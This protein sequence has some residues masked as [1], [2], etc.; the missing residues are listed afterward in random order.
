M[1]V[2]PEVGVRANF[3]F[4]I[5]SIASLL[6]ANLLYERG[7]RLMWDTSCSMILLYSLLALCTAISLGEL[8]RNIMQLDP[9]PSSRFDW[10]LRSWVTFPGCECLPI[11]CQ[12]QAGYVD[13][14]QY[15]MYW[16]R[17]CVA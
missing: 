4:Q 14:I 7:F 5:W 17:Q 6:R 1:C 15:V 12:L 16:Y 10:F 13:E 8:H 3:C 11:T 2:K 9:I